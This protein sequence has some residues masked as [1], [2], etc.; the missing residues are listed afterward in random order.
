MSKK[1]N[2]TTATLE[3]QGI[4]IEVS[5]E[6]AYLGVEDSLAHLQVR[7]VTPQ[8][9]PL[10]MTE[11][12]YR[13]HFVSRVYIEDE[14]GPVPYVLAWLEAEAAKPEW[15]KRQEKARQLSLF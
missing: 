7:A 15:K 5:Y 8:G 11:T 14:G 1:R 6:P 2:I 4:T 13:S 12:G 9:S 3:W 10:P